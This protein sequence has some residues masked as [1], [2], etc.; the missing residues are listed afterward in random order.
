MYA[1]FL[2][3]LIYSA[4]R[5]VNTLIF[6]YHKFLLSLFEQEYQSGK[7]LGSAAL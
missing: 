4:A 7:E 1:T 5:M 6:V 2:V 3:A